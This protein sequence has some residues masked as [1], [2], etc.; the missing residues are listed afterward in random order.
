M[1]LYVSKEQ[2]PE[3]WVQSL[4]RNIA[5]TMTADL[6]SDMWPITLQNVTFQWVPTVIL[7]QMQDA[8]QVIVLAA[9]TRFMRGRRITS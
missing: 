9:Q 7:M 8:L 5:K 1:R 6:L 2:G 3:S 4:Q